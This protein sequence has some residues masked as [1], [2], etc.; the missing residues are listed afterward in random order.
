MQLIS[1]LKIYI[2]TL[3]FLTLMSGGFLA[4]SVSASEI[5]SVRLWRAPDNTRI[6]FDVNGNINYH[7]FQLDNP[8][9]LVID[10]ANISQ[11][12]SLDHLN[13]KGSPIATVRSAKR[14][15]KDL[16]VVLVLKTQVSPKHFTLKAN[17]Q[18]SNR[19]VV[20]LFDKKRLVSRSVEEVVE[21]S[22]RKIIIAIDAG[23][24]GEDPGA[25]GPKRMREKNVVLQISKRLE[26]LFDKDPNYDGVLVRKGDYYLAHR[27]RTQIARDNQ[28]DFFI[29]IHADAFTDHRANGASVYALSNKGA[30]SEAARFLAQKQN[31]ADL[32]GGASVLNLGNKDEMLAGVLLDLSMTATMSTSLEAGKQVLKHMGSVARLHKKKV[33]QAGFL[34]LKSP[35]IPSL[36]IETGFISNPKE[37]RQLSNANYQQ[38]M[39]KA[40]FNGLDQ[41]YSE[42]PPEGTLLAKV[43]SGKPLRYTVA[44]GDTLSEISAQYKISM[45]KIMRYNKMSSS[46][47]RVGQEIAIPGR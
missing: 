7:V 40:I 26:K 18:Y 28:T 17:E 13:L 14:N 47:I 11:P 25:L 2:T 29:S 12:P 6:V 10:I 9:R 44:R 46:T 41:Y 36:L 15:G 31:N 34:V 4:T 32:I 30:T 35:D 38:R 21:Q 42:H 37:A 24:G 22:D 8:R 43:M 27:K 23:H 19:L 39:A 20:D 3:S 1:K 5:N 33:E 45:A 16:R